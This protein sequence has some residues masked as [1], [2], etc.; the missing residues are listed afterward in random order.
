MT[1]RQRRRVARVFAGLVAALALVATLVQ[2]A[3][4]RVHTDATPQNIPPL[5][6]KYGAIAYS[7]DG[8]SGKARRHVSKLGAEQLALSRCG[9][10]S[11]IVVSTFTKCGAVAHDGTTYHGGI[12]LTRTA[13]EIHAVNRLGGGWPVDWACN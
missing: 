11:C 6:T 3:H 8:S 4:A 9:S 7:P 5:L 13:A 1:T 12:G 10:P 2:P